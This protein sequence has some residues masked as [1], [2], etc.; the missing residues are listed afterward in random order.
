M[1]APRRSATLSS[2][3]TSSNHFP[4][5]RASLSAM[6]SA[7][8]PFLTGL[9]WRLTLSAMHEGGIC[10][11]VFGS[12]HSVVFLSP[13][14]QS[15]LTVHGHLSVLNCCRWVN[16]VMYLCVCHMTLIIV[17]A[18]LGF[19]VSL[20]AVWPLRAAYSWAGKKGSAG[21]V[22]GVSSL[23]LS[24]FVVCLVAVFY[25]LMALTLPLSLWFLSLSVSGCLAVGSWALSLSVICWVGLSFCFASEHT[26]TAPAPSSINLYRPTRPNSLH[27]SLP[28]HLSFL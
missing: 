6:T 13:A 26:E 24:L 7:A 2:V 17:D 15:M 8:R 23:R 18:R 5:R 11:S 27:V 21:T 20:S 3:L 16:A 28:T 4:L 1:R 14:E 9:W 25:A 10:I 12:K 19:A 22:S